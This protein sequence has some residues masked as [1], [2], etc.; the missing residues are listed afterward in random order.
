[1]KR[2]ALFLPLFL[3][4]CKLPSSYPKPGE[5]GISDITYVEAFSNYRRVYETTYRVLNR[6]GVIKYAKYRQ[7]IIVAELL[8]NREF[9]D[10]T[11]T[12]IHARIKR[13]GVFM[14]DPKYYDVEI[15]VVKQIDT[16]EVNPLSSVIPP[17]RWRNVHFDQELETF[18][19]NEI[20]LAL[21]KKGYF[22]KRPLPGPKAKP[23]RERK[24][25]KSF[26]TRERPSSQEDYISFVKASFDEYEKYL[27]QGFQAARQGEWGVASIYF[28]SAISYQP[29]RLPA[30]AYLVTSLAAEGKEEEAF[31]LL[32]QMVKLS[33]ESFSLLSL[34]SSREEAQL[35]LRRFPKVTERQKMIYL[36]LLGGMGEQTKAKGFASRLRDQYLAQRLLLLLLGSRP[37]RKVY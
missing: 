19:L 22:K 30:Y 13:R 1:M 31:L 8:T 23:K 25:E 37:Q 17:Y 11:R 24:K 18:F 32:K 21:T 27:E 3:L 12:V 16:S 10:K 29:K 15:R 36:F 28:R 2:L 33:L 26:P 6:Y 34:F 35:F 5:P 14:F 4:S 20:K 9:F 7:G